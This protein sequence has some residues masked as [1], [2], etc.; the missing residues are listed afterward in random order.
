M[1]VENIFMINLYKSLGSGWIELTAP[2]S[3]IR[4]ATDCATGPSTKIVMHW[5]IFISNTVQSRKFVVL[6]T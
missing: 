1:T 5:L 4:L 3:A 6:G 2:G